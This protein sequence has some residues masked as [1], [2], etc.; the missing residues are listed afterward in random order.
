M[1]G[2]PLDYTPD[3]FTDMRGRRGRRIHQRKSVSVQSNTLSL[4]IYSVP[5][6]NSP[7]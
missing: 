5:A 6:G 4:R 2:D 7:H 3:F 1:I